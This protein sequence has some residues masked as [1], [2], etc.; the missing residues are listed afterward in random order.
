MTLGLGVLL[1]VYSAQR[2]ATYEKI[3]SLND[4]KTMSGIYTKV[5]DKD[6]IQNPVVRTIMS[7]FWPTVTCVYLAVSFLTGAWRW[8]WL[9]WPIGAIVSTILVNVTKAKEGTL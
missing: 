1:I 3:L 6:M 5:E 2:I 7:V 8:T 9:I 4:S